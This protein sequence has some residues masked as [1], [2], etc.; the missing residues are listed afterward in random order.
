MLYVLNLAKKM[1]SA[2]SRSVTGAAGRARERSRSGGV[3]SRIRAFGG[4]E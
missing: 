1:I 2:L 3:A 4:A